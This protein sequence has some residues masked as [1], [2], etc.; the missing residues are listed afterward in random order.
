MATKGALTLV[1][2]INA[3]NTAWGYG[4]SATDVSLGLMFVIVD[5]SDDFIEAYSCDTSGNMTYIDA[6]AIA[7][8]PR[9]IDIDATNKLLFIGTGNGLYS[10]SYDVSGNL[11]YL[12]F[13]TDVDDISAL[14]LDRT[15]RVIICAAL[16]EGLATFTYDVSGNLTYVDVYDPGVSNVYGVEVDVDNLLIF[17]GQ[18]NYVRTM[19]YDVSGNLTGIEIDTGYSNITPQGFSIDTTNKLIFS[20]SQTGGVYSFSYVASGNLTAVD[21]HKYSYG[22]ATYSII[23]TINKLLFVGYQISGIVSYSYETSGNL[24]YLAIYDRGGTY[25][26]F[27]GDFGIDL[28]NN[29]IF[30]GASGV[31]QAMVD[32]FKYA[33]GPDRYWVAGGA[34]N[35]ANTTNWATSSGGPGGA[36]IPTPINTAI[37]DG[38]S[39]GNC[40]MDASVYV[41]GISVYSY[42]DTIIQNSQEIRCDFMSF[43]SG[44]FQ[45]DG[46]NIRVFSDFSVTGTCDFTST[47]MTLSCDGTVSYAPTTGSFIH[48]RGT[49]SLDGSGAFLDADMTM[50][51]LQFNSTHI[52]LNQN[53]LVEDQ[54]SL[55]T[56]SAYK[57]SD[58]TVRLT[59]DLF[60]SSEYNQ[61][62]S[63][64]DF[65]VE[66]DSTAKQS[67]FNE[68]GS[69]TPTVRV[70]KAVTDHVICE[71]ESPF[72]I[73]DEFIIQDGTFN[74]NSRDIQVGL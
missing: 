7:D 15:N 63:F 3:G 47:D 66:F 28:T 20:M 54:L 24:T 5:D 38:S 69:V 1:D 37:F 31:S 12:D 13:K 18:Y 6:Y 52:R 8:S 11:T 4:R 2:S 17:F 43:E 65:P 22:Q 9:W 49:V 74:M 14:V 25:D 53:C 21:N 41:N 59:G 67:I 68:S 61:W 72:I 32:S 10:L 51:K 56:G 26:F 70:N 40:T 73:K 62:S 55:R 58:S 50:S 71:G 34:S 48:N 27:A 23:D 44:S 60:C 33:L 57:T 45:G 39:V 35:W 46:S 64:N 19:K 16:S 42:N 29:I 30:N 36:S